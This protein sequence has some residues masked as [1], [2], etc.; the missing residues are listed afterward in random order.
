MSA[1]IGTASK[2]VIVNF[3]RPLEVGALNAAN[4]EC[5]ANLGAGNRLF[6]PV[7]VPQAVASRVQWVANDVGVGFLINVVKYQPPPFD[8]RSLVGSLPAVA[9][10]AFP[11]TV[12]P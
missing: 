8:V 5:E 1:T 7:G 12:L 3:D 11:I 4:W 10:G 9:F 6:Q 2:V